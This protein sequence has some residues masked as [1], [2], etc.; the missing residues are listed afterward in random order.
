MRVLVV[1]DDASIRLL[2]GEL[3]R[4]EGHDVVLASDH[5]EALALA[6]GERFHA[7]LCDGLGRDHLELTDDDRDTLARLNAAVPTVLCTAHS[8][9][10]GLAPGAAGVAGV[11]PKPF[12]AAA[13]LAALA[14]VADRP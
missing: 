5:A 9:A 2:V 10:Q 14:R 3:L 6:A 11:V 1:E 13:V 7:C 4:D 12:E 8:W